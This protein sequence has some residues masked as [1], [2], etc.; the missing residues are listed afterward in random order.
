MHDLPN[1]SVPT[2]LDVGC[3]VQANFPVE[4]RAS[5]RFQVGGLH[6]LSM[7]AG[8]PCLVGLCIAGFTSF[9]AIRDDSDCGMQSE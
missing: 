8:G 5:N 1:C 2:I 4:L 9:R 7:E 3:P 6:R